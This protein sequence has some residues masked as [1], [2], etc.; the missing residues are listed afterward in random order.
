MKVVLVVTV[1]LLLAC[2]ASA[3][4]DAGIQSLQNRAAALEAAG[5]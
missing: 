1:C 3:V 4:A 5:R 2:G